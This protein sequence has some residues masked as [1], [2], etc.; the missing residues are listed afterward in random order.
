[1]LDLAEVPGA[2]AGHPA[3]PNWA[4]HSSRVG[5]LAGSLERHEPPGVIRERVTLAILAGQHWSSMV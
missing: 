2:A 3:R 4:P 1:M 5:V